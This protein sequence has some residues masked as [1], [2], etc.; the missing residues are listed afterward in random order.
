MRTKMYKLFIEF[1]KPSGL[2]VVLDILR[3]VAIYEHGT[4]KNRTFIAMDY[5]KDDWIEVSGEYEDIK[6]KCMNALIECKIVS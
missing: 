5:D 3:M 1:T 6:E 2:K 4:N